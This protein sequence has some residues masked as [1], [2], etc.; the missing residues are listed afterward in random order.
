MPKFERFFVWTGG[1]LFV[2]A[3]AYTIAWFGVT[4]SRSLPFAGWGPVAADL[5]LFSVFALHHSLLARTPMKA[6]LARLV[7]DRL[8]RSVYVWVASIL[9]LLVC[10]LWQPVGGEFDVSAR[11][12]W[13]L[14]FLQL[15]GIWIIARAVRLIDGLQ[16]AGI[17]SSPAV[18][19]SNEALQLGGPYRI[20]RH[21]IYLGWMLVVFAS[22]RMTGGRLAFA[23]ISSLYLLLAMPWEERSLEAAFGE[24]YR[25]YKG[26]V[27]WRLLPYVY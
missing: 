10:L 25:R 24:Q 5:L 1:A 26:Q 9:L 22:S 16:L 3:L 15:V 12:R 20:V 13:P 2:G 6:A 27:R 19:G 18:L 17:R 11:L 23:A 8:I 21:P 4:L 14:T 7:P